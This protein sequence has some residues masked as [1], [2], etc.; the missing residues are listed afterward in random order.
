MKMIVE[1][2][3]QRVAP[4]G[5]LDLKNSEHLARWRWRWHLQCG[6]RYWRARDLQD[7]R[8]ESQRTAYAAILLRLRSA[9][10]WLAAH[11]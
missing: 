5:F 11:H 3:Q 7:L 6:G 8:S 10:R 2:K 1:K 4:F 9:K